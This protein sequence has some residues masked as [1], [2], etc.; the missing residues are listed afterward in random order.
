MGLASDRQRRIDLDLKNQIKQL[1]LRD[2]IELNLPTTSHI[3]K[4]HGHASH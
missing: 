3:L 1:S 2:L 4:I